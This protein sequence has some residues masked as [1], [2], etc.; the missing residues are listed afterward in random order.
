MFEIKVLF[1][2]FLG[3][4]HIE[5][6][7]QG[8]FLCTPLVY[9]NE[10]ECKTAHMGRTRPFNVRPA[11]EMCAP[12]AACILNFEHCLAGALIS[13]FTTTPTAVNLSK[14]C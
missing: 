6:V 3:C 9:C 4:T 12:G 5:T 13:R 2:A 1:C 14:K 8:I 10:N 7:R 11:A